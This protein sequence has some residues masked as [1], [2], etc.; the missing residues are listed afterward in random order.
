MSQ[1]EKLELQKEIENV[2]ELLGKLEKSNQIAK[3]VQY[4]SSLGNS[5]QD[6]L[7]R[8]VLTKH[9][10]TAGNGLHAR[11]DMQIYRM[12]GETSKFFTRDQALDY[13][14][15]KQLLVMVEFWAF[16]AMGGGL[17]PFLEHEDIKRVYSSGGS[18]AEV[19]RAFLDV[20]NKAGTFDKWTF[21]HMNDVLL[22]VHEVVEA[23]KNGDPEVI[24]P[25]KFPLPWV[26]I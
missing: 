14:T 7:K 18:A 5:E 12:M 21:E 8:K 20:Q 16:L 19:F 25:G 1:H 22:T 17:G 13:E 2:K 4:E 15:L 10:H 26:Y 11:I 6:H 24:S 9:I 3:V 23:F